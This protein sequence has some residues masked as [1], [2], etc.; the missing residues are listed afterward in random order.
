MGC[1][2]LLCGRFADSQKSRFQ[3]PKRS[4]M[5]SAVLDGG[6]SAYIHEFCFQAEKQSDMDCVDLQVGLF[7][8]NQEW[9]LMLRNVQIITVLSCK[10]VDLL[11]FTNSGFRVRNVEIRAV[12]S[13]NEF[14]LLMHRNRVFRQRN[15]QKCAVKS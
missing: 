9:D 13:C 11:M 5:C 15:D 7:A 12:L 4:N 6:R 2:A 14:G 10:S 3:D 1:Y 8:D